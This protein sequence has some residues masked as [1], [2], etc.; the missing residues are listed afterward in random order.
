[1][2]TRCMKIRIYESWIDV[3]LWKLHK[4]DDNNNESNV[5]YDDTRNWN[6]VTFNM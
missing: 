3:H 6:K 1:M 4:N 2:N 5:Y